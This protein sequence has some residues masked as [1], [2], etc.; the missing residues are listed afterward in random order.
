MNMLVLQ[1]S[2]PRLSVVKSIHVRLSVNLKRLFFLTGPKDTNNVDIAGM[3]SVT[4]E[5]T[6]GV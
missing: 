6:R 4:R 5:V 2:E 1:S 3:S